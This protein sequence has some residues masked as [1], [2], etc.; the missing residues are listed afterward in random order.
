MGWFSNV[1]KAI[2]ENV[3][4][5]LLDTLTK[6]DVLR[7]DNAYIHYP[8]NAYIHY[9]DNAHIHYPENAYIQYLS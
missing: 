2:N 9:P 5:T 4:L 3:F 1:Y 6:Q 8:D 7:P